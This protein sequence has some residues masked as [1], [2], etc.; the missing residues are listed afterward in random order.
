MIS[1]LTL[2]GC[3]GFGG[4]RANPANWFGG[5]S[6]PVP[7]SSASGEANPLI[8]EKRDSILRRKSADERYEGTPIHAVENVVIERTSGGAIIKA[9]GLSL[10]QGAY[11]V[12]LVPDNRDKP[13]GG[14]LTYSMR[15]LQRT[16]TPQGPERTR[17]VSAGAFISAQALDETREV[18]ILGLN[19][20]ATARR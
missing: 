3:S 16:D 9:T 14:V 12:R 20:T 15:A 18:R 1:S 8:P 7:A 19:N 4:S 13:V 2:A 17:R 10:R 11:D 6:A 5:G